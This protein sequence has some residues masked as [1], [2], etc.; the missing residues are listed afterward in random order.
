[1]KRFVRIF[2]RWQNLLGL[3]IIAMFMVAASA[4]TF[5][6]PEDPKNPGA[7][8]HVKGL[9]LADLEP[10]PPSAESI[11]GTLPGQFD[12]FHALIAGILNALSFGLSIALISG[13]FGVLFGASAAYI[14]GLANNVLMRIA[15]AFLAFPVIAGV[16]LLRVLWFSTVLDQGGLFYNNRWVFEPTSTDTPIQWLF[17]HTDPLPVI[18]ILFSWMPYARLTNTM[19]ATLKQADF[20][21]AARALG[22]NPVRVIL[23][24][25]VPNA[26][27][28]AV[29]LV[30]RDI[31]N[32]VIL[33]AT[34]TFI[35]ISG[36]SVWG[37]M[38]SM[39]RDWVIGAGGILTYWWTF[40]PAT[41]ALVLFSSGWNLLGDAFNELLDP[42]SS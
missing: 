11:L 40:L 34:F 21:Q 39:G 19:V 4:A 29:V 2:S 16:V 15:D 14:G 32:L 22:A 9:F 33:Q 24:H 28:P 35:G 8:M 36:G 42:H 31:G 12:T 38:L 23:R 7:F 26:I 41:L 17:Q 30:A 6:S 10:H 25:L 27:S 3:V 20:I 5:I 1:M 18:L 13:S 37:E